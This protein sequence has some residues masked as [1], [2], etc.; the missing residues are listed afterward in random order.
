MAGRSERGQAELLEEYAPIWYT[1]QHHRRALT[2]SRAN[3]PQIARDES[4]RC[5][6]A[7]VA[8]GMILMRAP[9][10][11]LAS[12]RCRSL[13]VTFG[14][15]YMFLQLPPRAEAVLT[16]NYEP[17]VVKGWVGQVSQGVNRVA[18]SKCIR[19]SSL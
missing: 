9:T 6:R 7:T 18:S 17:R 1:K 10:S 14:G 5:L 19:V 16:C 2:V 12:L 4:L 8:E 11:G 15:I 3:L 13:A